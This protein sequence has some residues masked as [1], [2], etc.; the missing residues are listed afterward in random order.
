MS[1][2]KVKGFLDFF[3]YAVGFLVHA[4]ANGAKEVTSF[5]IRKQALEIAVENGKLNT[6]FGN[7]KIIVSGAFT[8]LK[9]LIKS[10]I[11][12]DVVVIDPLS[13]AKQSSG[14]KLSKKISSVC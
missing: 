7:H 9:K 12:F 1:W 8:E 4:L 3:S 14:I 2:V 10:K 6:F 5:D 13:L 11:T